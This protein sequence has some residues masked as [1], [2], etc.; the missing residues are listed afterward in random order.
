M[1]VS[2]TDGRALAGGLLRRDRWSPLA[3]HAFIVAPLLLGQ[4][5]GI[6][7]LALLVLGGVLVLIGYPLVVLLEFRI[8]PLVLNPLSY[9]FAWH[10]LVLG[11][12]TLWECW[13]I[14]EGLGGIPFSGELISTDDLA[15]GYAIYILGALL[16]HAGASVLRPMPGEAG[17]RLARGFR[18]SAFGI[19]WAV[20]LSMR[21]FRPWLTWLGGIIG[22]ASHA[23]IAALCALALSQ[24]VAS[25]NPR[26]F[27]LVLVGGT[28]V[29]FVLGLLF[30]S[31]GEAMLAL[32]PI[33]WLALRSRNR[34]RNFAAIVA[35]AT[36]LYGGV[37]FPVNSYLRTEGLVD[38]KTRSV[39]GDELV[40]AGEITREVDWTSS[41]D[42]FFQRI[43]APTPVGYLVSQV[44][45]FGFRHGETM[46]YMAYAFVPRPLWPD[47]PVVTRGQWFDAYVNGVAVNEQGNSL[48]QTNAGELYWNFGIPGVVAGMFVM[49]LLLGWLWRMAGTSPLVD[50]LRMLLYVGLM[51]TA[52][53]NMEGEFGSVFVGFVYRVILFSLLF[54]L[55]S[56]VVRKRLSTGA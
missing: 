49:G 39:S 8:S 43:F 48:G 29:E 1:T 45:M 4:Q 46:D 25:R 38:T 42:A 9:F 7:S 28:L 47:K 22:V 23:S 15:A 20:G 2:G 16:F 34:M 26:R 41:A 6:P 24:D 44:R 5:L 33:A 31:K 3:L 36:I 17:R 30:N 14:N 40:S 50:P 12:A 37:V 11:A 27:W 53:A 19:L 52:A 13:T 21:L 51:L 35:V 55:G 10:W 18:W 56:M 32:L 54:R